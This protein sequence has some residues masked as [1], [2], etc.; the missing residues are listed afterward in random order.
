MIRVRYGKALKSKDY[1]LQSDKNQITLGMYRHDYMF[2][3]PNPTGDDAIHNG[4]FKMVSGIVIDS[5]DDQLVIHSS[6]TSARAYSNR[7][8]P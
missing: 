7:I 3:S 8:S 2:H 1:V 5:Y 4:N 6:M